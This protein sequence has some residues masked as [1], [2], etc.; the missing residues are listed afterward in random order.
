MALSGGMDSTALLLHLLASDHQ[1]TCLSFDYGQQH[2]LEL[3]KAKELV[4]HLRE[5]GHTVIHRTVDLSSAMGLFSS[6]LLATGGDVP[7]GHYEEDAMKA[8]VV[9]NRNAIFA[10]L[11]YGTALSIANESAADVAVALGV[12]SG[13]HAIY[14]DCRPEFYDALGA[15]FRIGNWGAERIAFVLPYLDM[16]KAGIL[17]D[18]EETTEAL[19]LGFDEVFARTLTSYA[20]TVDGKSH[21]KT[22]S[23]IERILAFHAVGRRD[24]FPY[25]GGWDAVL[26]HA[27]AEDQRH[28]AK[29]LAKRLTPLQWHV[30]Q[31]A[32]T[33]RAFTG[34]FWDTST[35][36]SYACICCGKLLFDD[37][38]KFSSGCGW[39]SFHSELARARIHRLVD[40]THGMIRTEVRCS[41][42]DAHLGHVFD[43]GPR[44]HGG[45]RY[46]INSAS[47]TFIP[48]EEQA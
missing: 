21:G 6:H 11:L 31:E 15:A 28:R 25:V 12:H 46:C 33:E 34:E 22:G 20:P 30:T 43:D 26:K 37:T 48:E 23:D 44:Q 17:F 7:E 32:G 8:T 19:G 10:S 42:C 27:L 47:L 35:K 4:A 39:P 1:V 5:H 24:P 2:R 41:T 38:Q 18:A 36:G 29:A 16:D 45:E 9:P 3:E 40:R 13:D 14:P